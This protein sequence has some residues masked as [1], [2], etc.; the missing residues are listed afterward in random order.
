MKYA[1]PQPG[2][3]TG[4]VILILYFATVCA[5]ALFFPLA[6]WDMIAYVASILEKDGSLGH[7]LHTQAYGIVKQNISDGDFIVLTSDRPYRIAQYEDPDAFITMLGFYRVKLLY[8]EFAQL[9]TN[10]ANPVVALRWVSVISAAGFGVLT[11]LWLAERKCL[12]LAPLAIIA[13]I[14]TGFSDAAWLATPDLFSAVF[15]AT[16][17]L[18][19]VSERGFTA[20]IAFLLAILA[21]PD[22]LALVGVFAVMSIVIRPIGKGVI[23][24]FIAG[25]AASFTISAMSGHPGWWVHMWFTN[26]E[27]VPTLEGFDPPFSI[28]TYLQI[29]VKSIVRSLVEQKWLGV[30]L[31]LVFLLAVMLRNNFSFTRREAVAMTS[32][33]VAIPAKFVVFPLHESRFYFAYLIALALVMIAAYGRQ[34]QPLFFSLPPLRAPQQ[35]TPD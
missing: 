3:I 34:R 35:T 29:V 11:L 5:V 25:L 2:E 16:G 32:I 30:L 15:L 9:L 12:A 17:V 13:L 18:L 6:N 19:Y 1:L 21:R 33:I 10:W 31:T 20:G 26:V 24:A 23:I 22:H 7:E 4:G 28:V 14:A 27:Y 8:V